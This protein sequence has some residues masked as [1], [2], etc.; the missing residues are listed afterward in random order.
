M[1][2]E[3]IF[4]IVW[5]AVSV[6][7]SI[8]H[9][10]TFMVSVGVSSKLHKSSSSWRTKKFATLKQ[11][12]TSFLII[13]ILFRST[14]FKSAW[15]T[16]HHSR[17]MIKIRQNQGSTWERSRQSTTSYLPG[18]GWKLI[19]LLR[20]GNFYHTFFFSNSYYATEDLLNSE[21]TFTV[22]F[23]KQFNF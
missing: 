12:E 15:I 5:E 14:S 1:K 10:V 3:G 11:F 16:W 22:N 2:A 19:L 7:E 17:S 21:V 18:Q 13:L 23:K 4:P 6:L 20:Y 9:K 8:G